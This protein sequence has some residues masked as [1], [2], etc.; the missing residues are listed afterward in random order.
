[1][2]QK[3]IEY[4]NIKNKTYDCRMIDKKNIQFK[5]NL[6]TVQM[7]RNREIDVLYKTDTVLIQKCQQQWCVYKSKIGQVAMH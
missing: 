4:D 7:N 6:E 1:M 2:I 5:N 3:W